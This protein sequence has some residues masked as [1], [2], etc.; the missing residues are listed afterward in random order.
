M[1]PRSYPYSSSA[2]ASH[3]HPKQQKRGGTQNPIRQP[4]TRHVESTIVTEKHT[5]LPKPPKMATI[6]PPAAPSKPVV[7][8]TRTKHDGRTG[9]GGGGTRSKAERRAAAAK[10]NSQAISPSVAA[11]LAMTDMKRKPALL[12]SNTAGFQFYN[13]NEE[14]PEGAVDNNN[15][16]GGI[17]STSASSPHSWRLLLS[18]P[19]ENLEDEEGEEEARFGSDNITLGSLSPLRSLSNESMPSLDTDDES[20]YTSSNPPTP[21]LPIRGGHA[22]RERGRSKS[23]SSSVPEDCASDHPLLTIYPENANLASS[24]G[25]EKADMRP[26]TPTRPSLRSNLTASLRR[27]KSVARTFSTLAAPTISQREDSPHASLSAMSKIVPERRPLPW[28]EPPDPALRRYLNPMTVSPV[29]LYSYRDRCEDGVPNPTTA[30]IQ[31]QTYWPG[32]KKSEKASTPPTFILA[33]SSHHGSTTMDEEPA[34]SVSASSPPRQREPRENSDFLRVIVM[35]MNMRKVGKLSDVAPG[36]AKLWL[37]ARQ[38]SSQS[39]DAGGNEVPRRWVSVS[40]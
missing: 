29:E 31:M 39:D 15:E 8:P 13:N 9:A 18:P 40:P 12:R 32:A 21:S 19:Q 24:P 38:A 7:I 1:V 25:L 36:R 37:P 34:V 4:S 6:P 23:V 20:A 30:S 5:P 16:H 17:T 2:A 35:E 27:F 33:S 10:H 28:T 22:S 14:D 26:S 3:Q 11:F